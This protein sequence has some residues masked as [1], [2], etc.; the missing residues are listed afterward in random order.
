M[1]D[2][3]KHEAHPPITIDSV[4]VATRGQVSSDLAD[5]VVILNLGDGVYYGLDAIGA[6]IWS[7]IQEARSLR[8]VRDYL[9]AEYDVAPVQCEHDLLALVQDLARSGLVEVKDEASAHG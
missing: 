2:P 3:S 1:L 7:Y 8:T 4:V 9:L 5:E 6:T